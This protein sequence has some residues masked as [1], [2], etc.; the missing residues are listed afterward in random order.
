MLKRLLI[1]VVF[2]LSYLYM[3]AIDYVPQLDVYGEVM[4]CRGDRSLVP[5]R[6]QGQYEDR[7]TGLYYYRF[8]YYSPQMRMYISSAPI[9][10]AG[11]NPT[12]YGYVQDV[13]TW[14]DSWGWD[15]YVLVTAQ[16]GWYPVYKY[17]EKDPVSYVRLEKGDTYKIGESQNMPIK[18]SQ[19]R[20]DE[21]RINRSKSTSFAVDAQWKTQPNQTANLKVVLVSEGGSKS[22]DQALEQ[23]LLRKY[24][25]EPGGLLP[26][27]N[28]ACH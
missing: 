3:G 6:N 23:Q 25:S 18:Y 14:L 21:A 28:K 17:G 7:E 26:P 16:D 20:L 19:T 9:G 5:F 22:A 10:L 8:R 24:K 27:G 2:A 13:N 12:L 11:N 1:Y 15:V 4:E